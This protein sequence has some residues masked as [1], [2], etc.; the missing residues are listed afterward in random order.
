LQN[1][2]KAG[3]STDFLIELTESSLKNIRNIVKN[4]EQQ[5]NLQ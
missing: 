4:L 1:A 5:V 2:F 3:E